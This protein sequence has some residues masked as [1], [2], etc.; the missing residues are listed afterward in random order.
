MGAEAGDRV[1]GAVLTVLDEVDVVGMGEEQPEEVPLLGRDVLQ[2]AAQEA[3]RRVVGEDVVA[4]G[5]RDGGER[6]ELVE[7]QLV[8]G[9]SPRQRRASASRSTV[10][11]RVNRWARSR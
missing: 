8:A 2:V 3:V 9:A 1:P 7:E 11:L 6:V 10:A 5:Q 4:P